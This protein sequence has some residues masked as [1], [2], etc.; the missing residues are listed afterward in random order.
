MGMGLQI[1]QGDEYQG[2]T[3]IICYSKQCEYM[4]PDYK[5]RLY[6]DYPMFEGGSLEELLEFIKT[7]KEHE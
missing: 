7:H 3:Y 4:K 1:S 5:G 2:E 6:R